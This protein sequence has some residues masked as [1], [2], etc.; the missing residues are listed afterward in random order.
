M[1]KELGCIQSIHVGYGGY[2]DAMIGISFSLGGKGWGVGDFWGHWAHRSDS[3]KWSE[4][5]R[6]EDLGKIML[7]IRELLSDSKKKRV[8]D[9]EGVP[10]EASFDGNILREWRIL[11]EVIS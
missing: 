3:A 4:E 1:R 8:Q 6:I 11:T 7:R 10:I 2:D 9:L 5:S